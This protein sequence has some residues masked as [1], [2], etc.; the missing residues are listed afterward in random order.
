M[1]QKSFGNSL[2]VLAFFS[3]AHNFPEIQIC[4]YTSII[5]SINSL[6]HHRFIPLVPNLSATLGSF[7]SAIEI[8]Y[9]PSL[10]S[11]IPV[12]FKVLIFIFVLLNKS[13]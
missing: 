8:S 10:S 5:Q 11:Y 13:F 3:D 2:Q 6:I 4:V 7:F 12:V 1:Y 9:S